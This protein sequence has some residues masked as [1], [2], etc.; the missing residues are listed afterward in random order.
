MTFFYSKAGIVTFFRSRIKHPR[1]RKQTSLLCNH[2]QRT[3]YGSQNES[4]SSTQH[5]INLRLAKEN[6]TK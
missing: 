3:F 6:V 1:Q 2:L 5:N 4:H